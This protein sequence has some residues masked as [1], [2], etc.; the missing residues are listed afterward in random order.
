MAPSK[1]RKRNDEWEPNHLLTNAS[2][3]LGVVNLS[4]VLGQP[5]AWNG[6]APEEQASLLA[7]APSSLVESP[8]DGS[9]SRIRVEHPEFRH[10]LLVFQ[11]DL[12]EG[13]LNPRWLTQSAEAMEA[14]GRGEFDQYHEEQRMLMFGESSDEG[15]GDEDVSVHGIA[16]S[17]ADVPVA[18]PDQATSPRGQ[19]D[20]PI[21]PVLFDNHPG[22]PYYHNPFTSVHEDGEAP[23]FLN[24]SVQ[25]SR[26]PSL[27]PNA[28][29][30]SSKLKLDVLVRAGWIVIG[31]VFILHFKRSGEN[32]EIVDATKEAT[33]SRFL[34]VLCL[35][36]DTLKNTTRDWT[37]IFIAFV[38]SD[39]WRN[40]DIY[41][42]RTHRAS[43]RPHLLQMAVQI[44]TFG[45]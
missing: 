43:T 2:S 22:R 26:E 36:E 44:Y 4:K 32:G 37:H 15:D 5:E 19:F 10:A 21:D 20:S 23:V 42:S 29:E 3:K 35:T 38:R 9:A 8:N 39:L 18:S 34:S 11:G 17:T 1:K 30:L 14:R 31:D 45:T 7:L 41:H 16:T 13:R 28:K 12:T 33:V 27:D 6:L 40:V 24:E 25:T